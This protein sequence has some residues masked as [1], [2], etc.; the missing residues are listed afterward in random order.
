MKTILWYDLKGFLRTGAGFWL[1]LFFFL[2]VCFLIPLGIGPD[3]SIHT[4]VAPS[5]L[6]I[7]SVF[8]IL[9]NLD[10]LLFQDYHEGIIDKI[11][12]SEVLLEEYVIAKILLLFLIS[13]LPL[14]IASP[15]VGIILNFPFEHGFFAALT[16]L[17]GSPALAA[18]GCFGSSL[19]LQTNKGYLLQT[20]V[21]L[22]FCIP[23]IIFGTLVVKNYVNLQPF[24]FELSILTGISLV[25]IAIF[26]FLT[27]YVI[28]LNLQH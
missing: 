12:V 11:M 19:V 26:P 24:V 23:I 15:F 7:G 22:P 6:W 1:A 4:L 27:S 25:S 3:R 13:C 20:I 17:I 21:V 10:K 9:L 16:I 14:V 28:K 18:I 8:S 2:I 5:T